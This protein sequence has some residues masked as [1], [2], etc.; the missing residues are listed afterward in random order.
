M[1]AKTRPLPKLWDADAAV[2]H[3]YYCWTNRG[4]LDLRAAVLRNPK[5]VEAIYA[6]WRA[7]HPCSLS[8]LREGIVCQGKIVAWD[9]QWLLVRKRN[10][11]GI[12]LF[13]PREK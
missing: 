2:A 3:L 8:V 13:H 10:G 6:L 7:D 4:R 12:L 1:R 9:R 11:S 5:M